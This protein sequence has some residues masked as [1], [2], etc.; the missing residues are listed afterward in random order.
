MFR[1][2]C[3]HFQGSKVSYQLEIAD[4]KIL[5]D[6]QNAD[7]VLKNRTINISFPLY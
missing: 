6:I 1:M 3:E 7:W 4:K 2:V 5:L